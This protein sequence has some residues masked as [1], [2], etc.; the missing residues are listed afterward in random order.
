MGGRQVSR[1]LLVSGP[2]LRDYETEHG[3]RLEGPVVNMG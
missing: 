2:P 3:S 1:N